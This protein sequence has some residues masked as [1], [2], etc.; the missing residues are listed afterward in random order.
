[1]SDRRYSEREI[2]EVFERA[3]R[4]QEQAKASATQE[5]LTLDE[6]QEIASSAGIAPEFVARAAESVALGEPEQGRM[7]FGPIPRGVFRTEFLPGPPTDALWEGLVA[8]LRRTFEAQGEVSEGP[9]VREW[10]NGNLRVTLEPAGDGSR[11]HLRTRR[12]DWTQLAG[13][14]AALSAVTLLMA[15]F[16]SLDAFSDPEMFRASLVVAIGS[17]F[18]AAGVWAGQRAWA[19]TREGQMEAIA[20]RA[21]ARSQTAS[22]TPEALLTRS[23]QLNPDLLD[24]DAPGTTARQ[25]VPRTRS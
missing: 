3:A 6:M 8:D 15:F 24:L 21:G 22:S 5:G 12:D 25:P 19:A 13:A 17:A 14:G 9:R 16:S 23:P 4:D 20:Q 2:R 1:M 18:G 10:R 11:L 7:T